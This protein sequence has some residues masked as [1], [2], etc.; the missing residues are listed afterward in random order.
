MVENRNIESIVIETFQISHT[1]DNLYF[2]IVQKNRP[3][4]GLSSV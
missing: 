3:P 4:K 1:A 2:L